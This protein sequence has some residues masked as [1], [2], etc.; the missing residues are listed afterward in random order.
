MSRNKLLTRSMKA[1]IYI[2]VKQPSVS[3]RSS[4]S[5]FQLLWMI[6]G[7]E[8]ESKLH[9][10]KPIRASSILPLVKNGTN[11]EQLLDP[12]ASLQQ[13]LRSSE[14]PKAIHCVMH[15][16]ITNDNEKPNNRL[17]MYYQI[18]NVIK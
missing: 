2:E 17:Q 16:E 3:I 14:E 13:S 4:C 18:T 1:D 8:H 15:Y 6:G 12:W 7:R 5:T 11:Q 9:K 10:S